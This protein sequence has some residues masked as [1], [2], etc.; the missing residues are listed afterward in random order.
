MAA[1]TTTIA[2]V[3][4]IATIAA[5]ALLFAASVSLQHPLV[6]GLR[7]RSRVPVRVPIRARSR[8]FAPFLRRTLLC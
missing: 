4:C 3:I 8:P 2:G 7:V 6:D 1:V 5:P